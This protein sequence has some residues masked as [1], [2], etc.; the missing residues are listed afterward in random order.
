MR[1]MPSVL[2]KSDLVV[3]RAGGGVFEGIVCGP[4]AVLKGYW[5]VEADSVPVGTQVLQGLTGNE[6]IGGRWAVHETEV[7]VTN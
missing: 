6:T 4:W 5:V 7:V 1:I 2:K 3:F